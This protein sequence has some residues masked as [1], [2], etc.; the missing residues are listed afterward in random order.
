VAWLVR[1]DGSVFAVDSDSYGVTVAVTER[2]GFHRL[3]PPTLERPQDSP[4]F[5]STDRHMIKALERPQD[6]RAPRR[7]SA[8]P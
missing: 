6:R 5:F 2:R 1:A 7:P 3:V 4:E 8:K